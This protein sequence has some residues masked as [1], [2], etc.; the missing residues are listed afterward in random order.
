[1]IVTFVS[2]CQKKAKARTWQILDTFAHRIGE[3]TWQTLIT[4]AGLKAVHD[5][6]KRTA[7]KNTAVACHRVRGYGKT[8]LQW[9]VGQ[10]HVFNAQGYVAVH[11]THQPQK[12]KEDS[13][14]YLPL[15]KAL[16]G[17]AALFHDW[18][19][20]SVRFQ[21]KLDPEHK[22]WGGDPYRHEWIS[23][24]FFA[25]LA[26]GKTD[27]EWL[28]I[29]QNGGLKKQQWHKKL[30]QVERP[31]K[32]L[33][34]AAQ[35][36]A[37]LILTHHLLPSDKGMK[38]EK[39][40][41]IERLFSTFS[42]EMGYS[43]TPDSKQVLNN[44][45]RFHQHLNQSE[46]WLE[47]VKNAAKRL[48]DPTVLA[49]LTEAQ[50][51][52]AW[53][54]VSQ[55]ARLSLMLGDHN[56]SSRE[57]DEKWKTSLSLYANTKRN[58]LDQYLDE[59]LVHVSRAALSV[60][61]LLPRFAHLRKQDEACASGVNTLKK[62]SPEAYAWQ[63]KAVKA[64]KQ[65]R[66]N[67]SGKVEE[68]GFFAINMASTG[69]GKTFANAKIMRQLSS[70]GNSLRYVLALGLRTLTL[71]TG[72]EYRSRVGLGPE[73]MAT[74]IGSKAVQELHENRTPAS[75]AVV[76]DYGS[77]SQESLEEGTVYFKNIL[78]EDRLSTVLRENKHRQFLYAPVLACT[79]DHLMSATETTRG[80]RYILPWLRMMSSDLVIDEIDDFTG[81]DL[82]AI[83]RLIHLAGM[84]G[85]K[86]MLSSATIP[87]AL[88]TG[89][90]HAYLEGWKMHRAFYNVRHDVSVAWFD[91]Y[92]SQI[93]TFPSSVSPETYLSTHEDFAKKR[94]RALKKALPKR[95]VELLP[96][97]SLPKNRRDKT[98]VQNYVFEHIYPQLS[99]LH[100]RHHTIDPDSGKTVSFGLLR[101]AHIDTCIAL[102]EFL[103]SQQPEQDFE[104]RAMAYHSRQVLLLRHEQEKHL[105]QV[106]KRKEKPENLPDS[107]KNIVIR[108]HLQSTPAKH[109]AFIVVATPVEEVGRDHDFD[110][111]IVEPSSFRS[112]IQ[113]AGRVLRHREQSV[114]EPNIMVLQRNISSLMSNSPA[115]CYPG[116]EEKKKDL[117]R[118]DLE[119][120]LK[121]IPLNPLSVAPRLLETHLD[122]HQ[123]SLVG[124][125]HHKT[126]EWLSWTS[127]AHVS[128]LEGWL[129]GQWWLTGIPQQCNK[130][131]RSHVED[132]SLHLFIEEGEK[133]FKRRQKRGMKEVWVN[134]NDGVGFDDLEHSRLWLK[135][136]YKTALE[137][138]R[139]EKG[140]SLHTAAS[141]YGEVLLPENK[142]GKECA[143]CD[144]RGL[145]IE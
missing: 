19:K 123:I 62:R 135:R 37:W 9:V 139:A 86:V 44:C 77:M 124:I 29:L 52:G 71:Q 136:D 88:A 64:L 56:Y 18:G 118:H 35:S 68:Q 27:Q 59:H 33:P 130:F 41:D 32:N 57:K 42:A 73:E 125:E 117:K 63:D 17:L 127:E 60:A 45:F 55:Y 120:L 119:V 11:R 87:P 74:L 84:L 141:R 12:Q 31:L 137:S 101:V 25:R 21:N 145:K 93:E 89:F 91:E 5:C 103:L 15:I 3:R 75:K 69:K 47:K 121:D 78:P 23:C 43:N 144:Q 49:L 138:I 8:E 53:R 116:Y 128:K 94:V 65:W 95:R 48:S 66:R 97:D 107:F 80:G 58:T 50:N 131:R 76:Q 4:E 126:R 106:L 83:G 129:T 142:V 104:I 143:Y 40:Y 140:M 61:H 24:L 67:L 85:Q 39:V 36:I 92:H 7:S 14:H 16:S 51:S 6:L 134:V 22:A 38:D 111:A 79:I 54:L 122:I 28:T 1:M 26:Q 20:A 96:L 108:Q 10:K 46:R 132:I 2:E 98:A 112:L 113:L 110:W 70:D 100:Q 115:Y 72:D 109:I 82:V 105:D 34:P 81:E 133:G 99:V 90:F 13:W 102:F 30:T 114:E